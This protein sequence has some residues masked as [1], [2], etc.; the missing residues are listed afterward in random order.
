M[1]CGCYNIGRID[2][3]MVGIP[4]SDRLDV[5]WNLVEIRV[6]I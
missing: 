2:G 3:R 1:V 5:C 4:V 6:K